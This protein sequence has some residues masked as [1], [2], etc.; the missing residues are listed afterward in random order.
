MPDNAL[1]NPS[2]IAFKELM[3]CVAADRTISS[4]IKDAFLSDIT[5]SDPAA[6]VRSKAAV[7]TEANI[8]TE[9]PNRA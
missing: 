7:E 3:E 6:L 1:S 9:P 8:V 2:E 5:N 4:R